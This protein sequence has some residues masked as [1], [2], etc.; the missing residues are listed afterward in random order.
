MTSASRP[1]RWRGLVGVTRMPPHDVATLLHATALYALVEI[2]LRVTSLQRVSGLLGVPVDMAESDALYPSEAPWF[3]LSEAERRKKRAVARLAPHLYG[4]ERGCLRRS[5]VLGRLLRDRH[6]TLH[7]GVRRS[8]KG[9]IGAHAWIEV[10]GVRLE[11]D[12]GWAPMS[13]PR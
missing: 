9:A 8:S 6:P 1:P 12:G 2:G 3:A 4:T 11:P 5:L 10:E 13:A 7:L